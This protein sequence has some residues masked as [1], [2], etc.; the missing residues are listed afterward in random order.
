MNVRPYM[1]LRM[2]RSRTA[3]AWLSKRRASWWWSPNS[4]TSCAPDTEN[5]SVIVE[6]ISAFRSIC[7]RVMLDTTR[8]TRFAGH[9]N[10]GNSNRARMVSRHS[11]TNMNVT[12][13][14]AVMRFVMTVPSVPVTALCAPMTSLLRRETSRPV[15]VWVKNANGIR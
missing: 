12:V 4:F 15:W 14:T 7:S 10:S 11:R 2:P 1:A 3:D 6:F 13:L 9:T 8:P 5:R